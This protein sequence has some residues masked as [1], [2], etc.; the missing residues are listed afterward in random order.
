MNSPF[1]DEIK[2][3]RKVAFAAA[4]GV[5]LLS[6][7]LVLSP[8]A[9]NATESRYHGGTLKCTAWPSIQ[10]YTQ[11]TAK[12]SVSHRVILPDGTS[13]S[14]NLGFSS[15]PAVW[16]YKFIW[17]HT[18]GFYSKGTTANG[19]GGSVVFGSLSRWCSS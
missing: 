6:I 15:F 3:A 9:A 2:P 5:A 10:T 18:T 11:S 1:V 14:A 13:R 16:G 12:G 7:T 8:L 17:D 4:L 19:T